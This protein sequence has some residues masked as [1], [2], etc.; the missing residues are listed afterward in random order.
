M[1][2]SVLLV[3]RIFVVDGLFKRAIKVLLTIPVRIPATGIVLE[4][5]R[6]AVP[7]GVGNGVK[8]VSVAVM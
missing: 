1:E 4:K 5:V 6:V 2:V 7:F 8:P 3:S